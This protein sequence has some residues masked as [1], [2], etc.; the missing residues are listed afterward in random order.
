MAPPTRELLAY[1]I[2]CGFM[3]SGKPFDT[4]TCMYYTGIDRFTEQEVYVAKGLRDHK[5][6]CALS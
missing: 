4:A 2:L 1:S 6:Q 3:Q 5:V